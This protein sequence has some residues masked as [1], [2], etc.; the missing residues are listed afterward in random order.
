MTHNSQAKPPASTKQ[1][2]AGRSISCPELMQGL[3]AGFSGLPDPR[4]DRTKKHRLTDIL[5]IALCAILSGADEWIEIEAFGKAKQEW[6]KTFLALPNGIPSHDTFARLFARLDPL[7]LQ[8]CFIVWINGL[9]Q[10]LQGQVVA[11][12]GKTVRRSFDRAAGKAAIHMVNAWVSQHH[13]AL[14]QIKVDSKSNEIVAIPQLLRL[15]ELDG[16]IVT[17]DAMGCQKDIAA[18]IVEQGADYVL[19]LKGNQGT[20]HQDVELFFQEAE[21]LQFHG[22]PHQFHQSV[23]GDHGRIEIRRVWAV[24]DLD[25]LADKPR[26]KGLHSIVKVEAERQLPDK[27]STETRYFISSLDNNARQLGQAVRSHWGIE[28]SLHWVL[29]VAFREDQS[30][31]RKDHAPANFA[32]MR[33]IAVNLLKR[34]QTAKRGV[35]CK[36]L[37]AAWDNDYLLKVLAS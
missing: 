15:L 4:I 7:A 11:I 30:R 23:E 18:Q 3:V 5:V 20:L 1:A 16:A 21:H 31:I 27:T 29:D 12:D 10:Q 25:W 33:Q 35:K 6:L 8:Q 36:R 19:A 37:K 2:S 17:I 9:S 13:L 28:N 32:M 26:W 14:G 34:E 22:I 24:S